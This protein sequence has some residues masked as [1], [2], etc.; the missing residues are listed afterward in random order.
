MRMRRHQQGAHEDHAAEP[1]PEAERLRRRI[2]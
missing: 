2:D 1:D